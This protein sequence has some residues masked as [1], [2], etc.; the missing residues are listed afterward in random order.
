MVLC[1]AKALRLSRPASSR[2]AAAAPRVHPPPP[3]PAAPAHQLRAPV[4][5]PPD[6]TSVPSSVFVAPVATAATTV[7]VAP[8]LQTDRSP[9][10]I[11]ASADRTTPDSM[12]ASAKAV[13]V[14]P[15]SSTFAVG[16]TD[17]RLKHPLEKRVRVSGTAD[18]PKASAPLS[19]DMSVDAVATPSGQDPLSVGSD[20]VDSLDGDINQ[21]ESDPNG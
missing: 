5:A 11:A 16:R 9:S 7:L 17:R 10:A 2:A 3:K 12:D 13:T 8:S 20:S 1:A 19:A 6:R 4:A 21:L 14:D 15:S 18:T